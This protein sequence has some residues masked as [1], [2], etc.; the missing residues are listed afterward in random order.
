MGIAWTWFFAFQFQWDLNFIIKILQNVGPFSFKL[1]HS[2]I[3]PLY[4]I[5]SFFIFDVV[6]RNIKK[7]KKKNK[8]V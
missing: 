3:C 2:M 1:H 5:L 8:T 7:K 6:M 4:A